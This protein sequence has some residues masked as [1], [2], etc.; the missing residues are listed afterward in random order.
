[1]L[2]HMDFLDKSELCLQIPFCCHRTITIY[3]MCEVHI[4]HEI[5]II[6]QNIILI[7]NICSSSLYQ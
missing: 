3:L 4:N 6:S 7:S 5:E 2:S 1:M